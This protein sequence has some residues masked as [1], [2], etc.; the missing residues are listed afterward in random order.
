MPLEPS[1]ITS[2][3]RLDLE[4]ADIDNDEQEEVQI[5]DVSTSEAKKKI[6]QR[7][8]KS[9][10]DETILDD[11]F[12]SESLSKSLVY[13]KPNRTCCM[14]IFANCNCDQDEVLYKDL[15]SKNQV[16]LKASLNLQGLQNPTPYEELTI[17]TPDSRNS[18]N[19]LISKRNEAKLVLSKHL[20][21]AHDHVLE[22]LD[23][24]DPLEP[25]DKEPVPNCTDL[26]V[27]SRPIEEST[28]TNSCDRFVDVTQDVV[29]S[30]SESCQ[31]LDN[32]SSDGSWCVTDPSMDELEF[33]DEILPAPTKGS[34]M[35]RSVSGLCDE[36]LLVEGNKFRCSVF[37]CCI[38]IYIFCI[39]FIK[40]LIIWSI[41]PGD[42]LPY[43]NIMHYYLLVGQDMKR[44]FMEDLI[45]IANQNRNY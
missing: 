30:F 27:T 23:E 38:Y 15:A 33:D 22:N 43:K 9:F 4:F 1:M 12:A 44:S 7:Q 5:L 21:H 11:K 3:T 6:L 2:L 41:L 35:K 8:S 32:R 42:A 14:T 18:Y 28:N 39:Y 34:D 13:Q 20:H 19:S 36:D 37:C 16:G 26:D 10:N 25:K 24:D 40:Y 31:V 17:L 29:P 45:N